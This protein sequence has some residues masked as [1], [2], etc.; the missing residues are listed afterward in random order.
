MNLNH[1]LGVFSASKGFISGITTVMIIGVAPA[2][3]NAQMYAQGY[4]QR[5]D[6]YVQGEL[7]QC[8]GVW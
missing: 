2:A 6:C 4:V 5:I 7:I 1:F 3:I 8:P